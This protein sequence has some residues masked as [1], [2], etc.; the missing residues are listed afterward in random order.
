MQSSA[1]RQVEEMHQALSMSQAAAGIQA[2]SLQHAEQEVDALAD[3]AEFFTSVLSE[4]TS[5]LDRYSYV[6]THCPGVPQLLVTIK[7][8]LANRLLATSPT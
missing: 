5:T 4:L 7:Q 6:L 3:E 1:Q 8:E 2:D